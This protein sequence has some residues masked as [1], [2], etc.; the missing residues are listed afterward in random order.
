ML[1]ICTMRPVFARIGASKC[2]GRWK[3]ARTGRRPPVVSA[4]A[5]FWGDPSVIHP[6]FMEMMMQFACPEDT[7]RCAGAVVPELPEQLRMLDMFRGIRESVPLEG[8]DGIVWNMLR[9]GDL[10]ELERLMHWLQVYHVSDAEIRQIVGKMMEVGE[11][12]Q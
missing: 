1:P 5:A 8:L 12:Q 4:A 6:D 10:G 7:L 3:R 9:V 11:A 2:S